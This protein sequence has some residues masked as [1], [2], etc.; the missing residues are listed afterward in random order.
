MPTALSETVQLRAWRGTELPG[1]CR[2]PDRRPADDLTGT[3]AGEPAESQAAGLPGNPFGCEEVVSAMAL[4]WSGFLDTVRDIAA[5][6]IL[7]GTPAADGAPTPSAA[8]GWPALCTVLSAR[9]ATLGLP[10]DP[11]AARPYESLTRPSERELPWAQAGPLPATRL[12]RTS[13]LPGW[14]TP[15]VAA[16]R[17]HPEFAATARAMARAHDAGP[18]AAS[19]DEQARIRVRPP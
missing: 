8:S 1:D 12:W 6:H 9:L 5:A 4:T 19:A 14:A 17:Y 3:P 18:L 10:A 2:V 16:L 13:S 15:A 7:A 11:D